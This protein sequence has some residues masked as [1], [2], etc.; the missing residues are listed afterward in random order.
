MDRNSNTYY[1]HYDGLG[2]VT[3]ITDSSGSIQESYRYSPYGNPSIFDNLGQPITSSAIGN[4]YMFTGRRWD[5]ETEIYY[6]R[7]RMYDP[8]IGRFLQRDPI[9]YWD[10]MNLY[11]YVINSP[12]NWRD[13]WGLKIIEFDD[14]PVGPII[15]ET[16]N[17]GNFVGASAPFNGYRSSRFG[18]FWKGFRIPPRTRIGMGR[19]ADGGYSILTS[20]PIQ[21]GFLGPSISQIDLGPSGEFLDSDL[22]YPFFPESINDFLPFD[23]LLRDQL[24]EYKDLLEW[25]PGIFDMIDDILDIL[26]EMGLLD[27]PG[28]CPIN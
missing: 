25:L 21:I 16:D 23:E 28:F 13:P 26:A 27:D 20:N 3:E 22:G 6:Y 5:D 1:Y 2:S 11:S 15:I 17:N 9:G 8:T 19:G 12:V 4:P 14:T 24:D 18:G 10:S 7:A